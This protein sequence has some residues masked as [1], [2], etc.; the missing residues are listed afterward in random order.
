LETKLQKDK[1]GEKGWLRGVAAWGRLQGNGGIAK[2]LVAHASE[3]PTGETRSFYR[4]LIHW[5]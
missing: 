5:Q 1:K 3:H 2:H 4:I